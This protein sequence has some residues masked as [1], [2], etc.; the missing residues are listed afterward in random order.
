MALL[1]GCLIQEQVVGVV[2]QA[3]T[4][5]N[6]SAHRSL[7]T[8]DNA[9]PPNTRMRWRT[10]SYTE[11]GSIVVGPPLAGVMFDHALLARA[12]A[13]TDVPPFSPPTTIMRS[14]VGS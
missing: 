11:H 8:M 10:G 1:G 2:T 4:A 5:V 6:D 3:S 9:A 12:I 7:D 13:H 14:A